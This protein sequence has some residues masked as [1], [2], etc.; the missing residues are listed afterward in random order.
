MRLIHAVTRRP[1]V[2]IGIAVV[3][4]L[5]GIGLSRR[6]SLRTS[7]AEL[8]PE[9]DPGVVALRKTQKRMGDLSLLL[10]GIRAPDLAASERY[11]EKFTQHLRSLPPEVCDIATYHMRDIQRFVEHNRWLYASE[12]DLEALRDRVRSE[13]GRRKNPLYVDLGDADDDHELEAR[14]RGRS[15]LGGR[16]PGGLFRKEGGDTLW[17]AALP[18]GGL[19]VEHAGEALL[20][21]GHDFIRQNPPASFHPRMD[22]ELTGPIVTPLRNK[23]ALERDLTTVALLCGLLIPLSMIVYFR[24]LRAVAFVFAPAVLATVMAYGVAFLAYGYLTTMTSFLVSFIMGNGTNYAVVLLAR[25]EDQRRAGHAAEK[26]IVEASSDLWRSTGVAAIASALSYLSLMVTSFRGFSQFGLIGAAGCLLAWT[27]TFTVLPAL[28]CL[29]DRRGPGLSR[30]GGPKGVL[31]RLAN[32]IVR[33]PAHVLAISAAVTLICAFGAARFGRETFEYDFRK[34]SSPLDADQRTVAFDRDKDVLFGRLPQPI[35]IVADRVGD[36][37]DLR[38]AIRKADANQPGPDVIGEMY[39]VDDLLPGP[40]EV[41]VRKLALLAD[42]RRAVDHPTLEVLEGDERRR[43]QEVRPPDD[44]RVVGATDLPPL[45]LRPFT[46]ADGSVGK[47]LLAY[48]VEK[49][50]SVYDGR[51][52]LRIANVL[53]RLSLPDGRH[54]DTSGNAVVFSAMIRSILRDGP[55]ATLASLLAVALLV[56]VRVRPFRAALLVMAGLLV[57]VCWMVGVAGWLGIK[58]T[59]L[60]FIALPFIFGVGVEYAIHVVSEF[61]QTESVRQTV[62][63]AGGPIAL[64][65]WSAIVG[66]GSL[67]GARNGALQGLGGITTLGEVA[68]LLAAVIAIPAVLALRRRPESAD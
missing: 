66:Y 15:T 63:A 26:A 51:A 30:V 45:A 25:Y 1:W 39:A 31:S 53:A 68:C 49:G 21:A 24:R 7:F 18:P 22:V 52:L 29:F 50:L 62:I 28:V 27:A 10:I 58:I 35:V 54:L 37:P 16:F 64:C 36:V 13:I 41:Q 42:I 14:L 32:V 48:P 46:E 65:S 17:I 23:K 57:G 5:V 43:L 38:A 44:L 59:F 34:L 60:N 33:A 61:K 6:L 4:G 47:V 20:A 9:T 40:A 12:E 67:L 8:L 56:F 55:I 3:A 19:F 2:A 11:A